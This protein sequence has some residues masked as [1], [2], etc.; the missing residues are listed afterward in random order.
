MAG[1]YVVFDG[2]IADV[3]FILDDPPST[4]CNAS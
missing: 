1:L 2:D 3:N 4:F